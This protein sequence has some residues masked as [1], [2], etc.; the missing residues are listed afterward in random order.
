MN[1]TNLGSHCC[2]LENGRRPVRGERAVR[3][4]LR[5]GVLALV[6]ARVAVR[7]AEVERG[8]GWCIVD[9]TRVT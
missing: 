1:R 8:I 3:E 7:A 4:R 2:A 6:V 9:A 5:I